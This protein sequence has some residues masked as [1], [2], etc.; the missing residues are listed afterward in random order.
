MMFGVRKEGG[1]YPVVPDTNIHSPD[2][3]AREYPISSSNLDLLAIN[4][5]N[6]GLSILDEHVLRCQSQSACEF[7]RAR[8]LQIWLYTRRIS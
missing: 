3:T 8:S 7:M 1:L 6:T 4:F 5:L 2:M